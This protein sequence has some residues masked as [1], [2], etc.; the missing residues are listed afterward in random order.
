MAPEVLYLDS[1]ALLCRAL[2][3]PGAEN[4]VRTT[5]VWLDLGG[6]IA[7]SRLLWLEARR[8][9]VRERAL[10]KPVGDAVAAALD[11]I[12]SLPMSDDVWSGAHAIEQ[13]VTTLDAL[14]LATCQLAGATLLS[15]DE[16]MNS[17]ANSL[18]I[19]LAEL[20]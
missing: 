12:V 18:G 8:V 15:F 1:S 16:Q 14:H 13:H 11:R 2:G 3:Q 4:V 10:G 9:S 5:G 19:P 7:S 17:V 20:A 6:I